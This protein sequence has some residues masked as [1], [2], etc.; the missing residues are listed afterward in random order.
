MPASDIPRA[1][2]SA[3]ELGSRSRRKS[4]QPIRFVIAPLAPLVVAAAVGIVAD[5]WL[6]ALETKRW[7]TIAL[8]FGVI[9]IVTIRHTRIFCLALLAGIAAIGAGWHHHCWSDMAADDLAWSVAETPRPT[10]ARG[11]VIEAR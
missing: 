10:W 11:V 2:R 7:G 4:S 8:A 9:A 3:T 1:D 5:R 6:L